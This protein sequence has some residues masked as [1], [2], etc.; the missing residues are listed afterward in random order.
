[1]SELPQLLEKLTKYVWCCA[2]I[3]G[4]FPKFSQEASL[5]EKN[6]II[7][8][9]P[10]EYFCTSPL[11]DVACSCVA[12]FEGIEILEKISSDNI[13][14]NSTRIKKIWTEVDFWC[15]KLYEHLIK[16]ILLRWKTEKEILFFIYCDQLEHNKRKNDWVKQIL[17]IDVPGYTTHKEYICDLIVKLG[18][19]HD[20]I[21]TLVREKFFS[22]WCE[23]VLR[24]LN[25]QINSAF[26][27]GSWAER[28][29]LSQFFYGNLSSSVHGNIKLNDPRHSINSIITRID[30]FGCVLIMM[31]IN[32]AIAMTHPNKLTESED[33]I[34]EATYKNTYMQDFWVWSNVIFQWKQAK[35]LNIKKKEFT[36]NCTIL[37]NWE[38]TEVAS[39]FL[40]SSE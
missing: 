29:I 9:N 23:N 12:F 21:P 32:C 33:P 22:A 8:R 13:Q 7:S 37:C 16:Y 39:I 36:H 27:L 40:T 25:D 17:E 10:C 11:E 2:D 31:V 4:T 3:M 20:A 1:M 38:I 24:N 26:R 19:P 6:K 34:A 35:I 28:N 30:S 15:R 18:V 14:K 5:I